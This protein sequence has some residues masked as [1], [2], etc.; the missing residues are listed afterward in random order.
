MP[1]VDAR[2]PAPLLPLWPIGARLIGPKCELL[3]AC[4]AGPWFFASGTLFASIRQRRRY[5]WLPAMWTLILF[6]V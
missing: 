6:G 5:A 3:S 4:P 1:N 2:N